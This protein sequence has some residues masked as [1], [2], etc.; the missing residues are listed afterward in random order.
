M[1][2]TPE[3]NNNFGNRDSSYIAAGEMNGIQ[4]LVT[5]FFTVMSELPEAAKIRDMH[6]SGLTT[7]I[8]KLSCF[9]SG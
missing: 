2:Q 3:G 6:P 9:L 1:E 5:C 7:S 4:Q 8:D